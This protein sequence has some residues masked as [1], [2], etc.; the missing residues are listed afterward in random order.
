MSFDRKIDQVCPHFVIEE[1]LYLNEDRVTVK[2][3][4]PIASTASVK[5][6]VNGVAHIPSYGYHIPAQAHGSNIGPFDIVSGVNDR[7][8]VSI[9]NEVDQVLT[10]PPGTKLTANQ[11]AAEL[12]KSLKKA[13]FTVTKRRRL[14]LSTSKM[15]SGATIFVKSDSTLAPTLGIPTNRFW[16]GR[17]PYSGWSVVNDPRSLSDRPTRLIIFDAPFNGPDNYVELNYTTIRQECRRCGGLGVEHDWRYGHSGDVIEVREEALLIQEVY[18]IFYTIQASN[19]FHTWY[20]TNIL[21]TI[22]RKRTSLAQSFIVS[23]LYEAFRRWQAIK[24]KQEDEVGQTVTDNEYPFR[25]LSVILE[26]SDQDPTVV[27]VKS[28]IM[29]RS[30]KPI[31]IER[32]IQVPEPTDL[33]SATAQQGVYRQSLSKYTLIE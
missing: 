23:D 27:F 7:F 29:N 24:R 26:Q 21:N 11:L 1:A 9:N 18:K 3:L 4:R 6:R 31:Q 28:T 33:L 19:P 12:S 14:R 8:V 17:T 20:G 30:N 15:G 13:V 32:G 2:P 22:G 16:Y 5:V 10:A 25:L